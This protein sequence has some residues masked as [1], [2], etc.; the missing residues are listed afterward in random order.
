MIYDDYAAEIIADNINMLVPWYLM[1]S[2]AYYVQDDSILSD[3]FYD[4]M[5][6]QLLEN[7]DS[8][9]HYHKHLLSKDMLYAG[10]FLGE[11]PSIIPGAIEEMKHQRCAPKQ[12]Q[13]VEESATGLDLFEW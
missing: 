6:K 12:E 5:A 9:K 4:N 11:Y 3:G 10:S 1:A 7:F 13:I 8:I 2:Y